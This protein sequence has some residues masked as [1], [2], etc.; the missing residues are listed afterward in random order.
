MLWPFKL[1][2]AK[3]ENQKKGWGTVCFMSTAIQGANKGAKLTR[4]QL[5]EAWAYLIRTITQRDT[6]CPSSKSV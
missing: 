1:K 4:E 3:A 2:K 6:T 5:K